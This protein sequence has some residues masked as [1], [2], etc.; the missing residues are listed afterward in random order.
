MGVLKR[1]GAIAARQVTAPPVAP[2][3]LPRPI[4]A[5]TKSSAQAMLRRRVRR[6][7]R[8]HHTRP[9]A[10][11]IAQ[12]VGKA[13]MYSCQSLGQLAASV[14]PEGCSM[15]FAFPVCFQRPSR[16]CISTHARTHARTHIVYAIDRSIYICMHTCMH[17]YLYV[18]RAVHSD[19]VRVDYATTTST[20][21]PGSHC[22]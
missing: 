2:R 5:R 16:P 7:P 22:E 18:Q 6:D 1:C 11:P 14:C 4:P 9:S 8:P 13:S 21:P 15:H 20:A 10:A 19:Q 3:S 12:A 17:I